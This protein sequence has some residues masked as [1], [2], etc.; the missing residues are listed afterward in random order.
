MLSKLLT[1]MFFL[2]SMAVM[3][4]EQSMVQPQTERTHHNANGQALFPQELL[5]NYKTQA[6]G[7]SIRSG[8]KIPRPSL[9]QRQVVPTPPDTVTPEAI[10][11]KLQDLKPGQSAWTVPWTM[12]IGADGFLYLNEEYSGHQSCGGTVVMLVTRATDGYKVDITRVRKNFRWTRSDK[13]WIGT[14]RVVSVL[15]N[16]GAAPQER[17]SENLEQRYLK[18]MAI[19]ESTWTV[20]WALWIRASR[21]VW[22]NTNTTA[23]EEPGGTVCMKVTRTCTGYD[24]DITD[25]YESYDWNNNSRPDENG[26]YE[27]VYNL[28]H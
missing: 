14:G 12:N 21:T 5:A 20:P 28:K 8:W 24:I 27:P 11:S 15:E 26:Y 17:L 1:C 18:D 25:V 16:A 23:D 9:L 7:G 6:S 19:G 4:C 22:L 2:V 10:E 3:G 13:P